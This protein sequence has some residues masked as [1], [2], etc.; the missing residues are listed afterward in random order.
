[1]QT[2]INVNFPKNL[3]F[4]L[5][6]QDKEFSDEIKKMAMIKLFEIGKISSGRAAEFLGMT[7]IAFLEILEKYNV[8]YFSYKNKDE[9]L[10]D[11][12]NA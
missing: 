8:S 9:I 3:A 5:K 1:M 12:N 4:T 10:E 11:L 6:M 7:R 2:T